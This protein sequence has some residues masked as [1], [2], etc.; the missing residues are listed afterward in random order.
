[1]KGFT[2]IELMIVILIFSIMLGAAYSVLTMGR[3][4]WQ[5][6]DIQIELQQEA[7]NAMDQMV[8][9]LRESGRNTISNIYQ[10]VDPINGEQ[11]QAISFASGRGNPN[12]PAEDDLHTNNDYFHLDASGNPS[13][14]SLIIYCIYQASGGQKQLR[15]YTDYYT[16]NYSVANTFPFTFLGI[17]G[18]QINLQSNNDVSINISRGPDIPVGGNPRVLANYVET[19]DTNLNRNL[20]P[21]EDDG[22]ASLPADNNNGI[23][24]NGIDFIKTGNLINIKLFLRK[25]VTRLATSG[26]FLVTTLNSAVESRN[27]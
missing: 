26:R 15:K 19:E 6:G 21:N 4:S 7:R 12:D 20:D 23:L 11:H 2:L 3:T 16:M 5:T 18:N 24:D 17:T 9:E 8:K 25:E 13:W 14:R 1:V 22:N 27:K 10:F